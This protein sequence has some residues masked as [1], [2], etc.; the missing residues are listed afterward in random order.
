MRKPVRILAVLTMTMALAI[1]CRAQATDFKVDPDHTSVQF[2]VR[3]LFTTVTGRFERFEGKIVFDEN[4]PK[5]TSVEGSIDTD[6]VN[7]NVAKRDKHLKSKDFFWVEKYPKITFRTT[8][9]TDVDPKTKTAKLGG[10]LTIRGVEKPV[11]LTA[12]FLGRGK[13]PWGNERAGFRA[14]TVINRKDF[15][16]TWNQA[17]E[18]GGFLVGDEVTLE[19][20]AEG[21]VARAT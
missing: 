8:G 16:L 10:V 11:V 6:S 15:G 1:P 4:D 3:H 14:T 17:L 19:I 13:D 21:L 12:E 7:T 9:V 20:N 2:H 5:K 18:T